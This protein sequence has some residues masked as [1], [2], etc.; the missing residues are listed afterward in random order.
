MSQRD[1]DDIDDGQDDD[2][3][4]RHHI[5]DLEAKA[6]EADDLRARLTELERD[7]AFTRALGPAAEHP[8]TKYF[9]KGYEGELTVDAIRAAASEAG[10]LTEPEQQRAGASPEELSAHQRMA[11]A[12]TGAGTSGAIPLED[13]IAQAGSAE[14][15]MTLMER[16]GFPTS[17]NAY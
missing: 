8:G 17:R 3:V 14:E 11:A 5:R 2:L 7:N 12:S 10:F 1:R 4:P 13:A 15:V 6:R 16:A 9:V